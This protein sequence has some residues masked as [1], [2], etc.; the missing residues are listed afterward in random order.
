M[1]LHPVTIMLG[2]LIFGHFFGM[3]G[4]IFATPLVAILKIIF[5]FVNEKLDLLG[6]IKEKMLYFE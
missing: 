3:I 6:K 1:E 2:L 5:T 4:M